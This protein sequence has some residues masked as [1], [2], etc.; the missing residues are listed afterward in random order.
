MFFVLA[1]WVER[2]QN[3]KMDVKKDSEIQR[4]RKHF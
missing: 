2:V 4:K 1:K 3:P